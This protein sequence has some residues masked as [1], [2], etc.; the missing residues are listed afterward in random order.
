MEVSDHSFVRA[1]HGYHY[2][3]VLPQMYQRDLNKRS[4]IKR[5][6]EVSNTVTFRR[7]GNKQMDEEGR[8]LGKRANTYHR[9][10]ILQRVKAETIE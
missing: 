9:A 6:S 2:L 4:I 8:A 5:T 10:V 3:Y 7:L 1:D